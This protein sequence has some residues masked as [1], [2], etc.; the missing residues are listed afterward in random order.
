MTEVARTGHVL[1]VVYSRRN[2]LTLVNLGFTTGIIPGFSQVLYGLERAERTVGKIGGWNEL[3]IRVGDRRIPYI[4]PNSLTHPSMVFFIVPH[5]TRES[6]RG[7]RSP[8][9]SSK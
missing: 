5:G 7:M 1:G 3:P 2:S 6:M 4:L 9:A 8:C